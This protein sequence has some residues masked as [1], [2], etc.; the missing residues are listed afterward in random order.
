MLEYRAEIVLWML[1]GILPFILM[2]I[3]M[4][5][6]DIVTQGF[7]PID[8]ARYFL[9][10][11]I[12][13]QL[14]SV[15]VIWDFEQDVVTG[16]LSPYLLQP[17]D[18]VWRYLA[19]HISERLSRLPFLITLVIIFFTLYPKAFWLLSLKE[20]LVFLLAAH[21]AFLVRFFIQYSLSMLAFWMERVVALEE[22][23]YLAFLFL[24]GYVAPLELFPESVRKF[25]ML[26]PFPYMV[27]FPVNVLLGREI[28]PSGFVVLGGWFLL[29]FL[30]N[31]LLWRLGLKRYSAM[32]A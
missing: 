16:Q 32:G 31:R 17:M 27:S 29:F 28:S 23:H 1:S 6:S 7:S 9:A 20:M 8:F 11:F 4:N 2:A 10:V 25:I 5:A 26:T 18:P 12:T 22:V 21:L 15:W 13:H 30:L 24:S 3:W 19:A 14:I